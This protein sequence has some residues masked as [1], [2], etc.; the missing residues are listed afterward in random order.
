MLNGRAIEYV[1]VVGGRSDCAT[2]MNDKF[3]ACSLQNQSPFEILAKVR[4]SGISHRI[5]QQYSVFFFFFQFEG[6]LHVS[7]QVPMAVGILRP[8]RLGVRL[9][10]YIYK[11]CR[12]EHSCD[13]ATL[14]SLLT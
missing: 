6:R 2:T 9:Y 4:I 10:V 8:S 5:V 14:I 3:Y 11:L 13:R 1:A 7:T 12:T